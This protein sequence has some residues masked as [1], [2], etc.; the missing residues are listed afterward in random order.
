MVKINFVGDI[1]LFRQFQRMKVDPFKELE[2]PESDFNIGNFEFV[3]PN[4]RQK[5][6]FDVADEYKTDYSYFSNL[7][8]N[9]FQ[10]FGLANNHIMDYGEEGIHDV[11]KVFKNKNIKT[12]GVGQKPFNILRITLNDI[13]FSVIACVKPGR[14]IQEKNIGPDLY[15]RDAIIQE[16]Q[17]EKKNT[18]HVIIFT[19]VGTE[20]VN[21]PDPKDVK[22][23]RDFISVGASAVIGHHP[24]IIQ[25][26]EEYNK[27]IIAY[28]LGS[29]IYLPEFEMGYSNNQKE[30]RNFSI[31][32]QLTFNK[33][34]VEKS[35][36]HYYKLNP[37]TLLP[38]PYVEK[39]EHFN[40]L[41]K[42]IDEP[43]RYYKQIRTQLLKR[44][45]KSFFQRFNENP[46]KTLRH[47]FS[48]LKF[49][50]IKTILNR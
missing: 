29:F 42:W 27:G 25:G 5:N 7:N 48:Y 31:C 30:E 20:L 17:K 18:D 8:L 6:F 36:I 35:D 3:I 13:S 9:K 21:I 14:W 49:K 50:H 19:H 43:S 11:M 23:A 39:N 46:F 28:S 26:I 24:H 34:T 1:A 33:N 45:I 37:E 16:I 12:F 38:S 47:Y 15:D 10:A 41:N 32:L 2:L 40:N 4:N 44:E 22:N